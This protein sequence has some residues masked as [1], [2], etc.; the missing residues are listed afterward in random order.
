MISRHARSAWLPAKLVHNQ[1]PLPSLGITA[2][3]PEAGP[4]EVVMEVQHGVMGF[5]WVPEGAGASMV[6]AGH[7]KLCMDGEAPVEVLELNV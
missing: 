7:P 6:W 5:S 1:L 2:A 3:L 4:K